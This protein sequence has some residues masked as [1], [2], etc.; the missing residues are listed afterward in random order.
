MGNNGTEYST[1][2]LTRFDLL[3]KHSLSESL[4]LN[5]STI[6]AWYAEGSF[7]MDDNFLLSWL[8]ASHRDTDI[9]GS[10]VRKSIYTR[11]VSSSALQLHQ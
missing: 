4:C 2:L 9:Q 5:G 1:I 6:N 10:P 11:A 7:H 8:L 3:F